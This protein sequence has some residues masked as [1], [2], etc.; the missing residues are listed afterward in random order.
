MFASAEVC[1]F[2]FFRL[3]RPSFHP[4]RPTLSSEYIYGK[5][6]FIEMLRILSEGGASSFVAVFLSCGSAAEIRPKPEKDASPSRKKA[7]FPRKSSAVMAA[8]AKVLPKPIWSGPG[9]QHLPGE[10]CP[11]HPPGTVPRWRRLTLRLLPIRECPLGRRSREPSP[12]CPEA[13]SSAVKR[14]PAPLL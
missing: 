2:N 9:W 13:S 8:S 11:A 1:A 6:S 14:P 7:S 10:I 3:L 5:D 12:R 4:A